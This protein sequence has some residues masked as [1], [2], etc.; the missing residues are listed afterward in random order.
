MNLRWLLFKLGYFDGT[1]LALSL[2]LGRRRPVD[3]RMAGGHLRAV[4]DRIG[5]VSISSSLEGLLV[6]GPFALL[7]KEQFTMLKHYGTVEYYS[8]CFICLNMVPDKKYI[9]MFRY[10]VT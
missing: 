3:R 5:A 7:A 9:K 6:F 10:S 2:R 8:F 4:G 1:H